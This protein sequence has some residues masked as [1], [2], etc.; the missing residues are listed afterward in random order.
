V[1][2]E[3]LE[4]SERANLIE[5]IL[6]EKGEKFPKLKEF[7]NEL[8]VICVLCGE[9]RKKKNRNFMRESYT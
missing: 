8:E 2:K 9:R 3:R 6:T 7:V 5:N 4:W 1:W